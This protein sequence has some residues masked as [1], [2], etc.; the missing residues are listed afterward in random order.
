MSGRWSYKVVEIK[1][2][3]FGGKQVD[4]IQDALDKHGQQGWELV[5]AGMGGPGE[6]YKLIFKKEA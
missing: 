1:F 3:L 4:R 5:T 6:A 2:E